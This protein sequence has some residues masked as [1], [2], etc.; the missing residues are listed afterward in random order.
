M[1]ATEPAHVI[2]RPPPSSQA[3]QW[4]TASAATA[5]LL[6]YPINSIV[7]VTLQMVMLDDGVATAV[8]GAVAGATPGAIYIRA[9]NSPLNNNLVP[10]SNATI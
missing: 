8:G 9:L 10:V 2:S 1:G 4:Q 5:F 3:A 7:D 6:V